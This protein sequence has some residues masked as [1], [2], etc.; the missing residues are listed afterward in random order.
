MSYPIYY[1][2][3]LQMRNLIGTDTFQD[4]PC[5]VH[6]EEGNGVGCCLFLN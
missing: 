6:E 5:V 1:L 2:L 3:Y 4:H